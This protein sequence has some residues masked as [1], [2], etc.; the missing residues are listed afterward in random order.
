MA[1]N[2]ILTTAVEEVLNRAPSEPAAIVAAGSFARGEET[3]LMLGQQARVLGDAEFYVVFRTQWEVERILPML[4]DIAAEIEQQLAKSGIEC[5]VSLGAPYC[6]LL[7]RMPP[8]TLWYEVKTKGKVLW[9]DAQ[10]L[11]IVPA[12]PLEA[13]PKWD[14]WRSV[15]NRMIEQ[16]AFA[17]ATKTAHAERM[18]QLL[19]TTLKL[20]IELASFV[21]RF[22]DAYQ[23]TYRGRAQALKQLQQDASLREKLPWLTELAARVT[24]CTAFK[25]DPDLPSL[26]HDLFLG[27]MPSD[28]Q[29]RAL[30]KETV[31]VVR[32]VRLVW[33]WGAAQ[34][35]KHP[36]KPDSNPLEIG[37][38][39]ARAQDLDW[40]VRGWLRLGLTESY[41]LKLGFWKDAARLA[42]RGGPRFLL[43]AAAAALYFAWEPWLNGNTQVADETAA[44]AL[45]YL[46]G[47]AAHATAS[48]GWLE[49]TQAVAASWERFLKAN[50]A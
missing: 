20:Q 38:E 37:L 42:R 15:A 31:Q 40:Q 1:T 36:L 43:Y 44:R 45:Q 32:L 16:M 48:S 49:A 27:A 25:L 47:R 41:W 26:Y 28:Q 9:G 17:G 30:E 34:L 6:D 4:Q 46:P 5:S 3:I 2:K 21:L 14:M 33:E 29:K 7:R 8:N 24:A 50:W 22:H 10:I 13:L 39:I 12:W 11:D 23:P 35:L 19:Y 18:Q